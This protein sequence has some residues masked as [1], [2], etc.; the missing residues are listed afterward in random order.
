[1]KLPAVALAAFFCAGIALGLWCPGADR[2]SSPRSL[3]LVIA[4]AILGMSVSFALLRRGAL[5]VSASASLAVWTVLG[6]LGAAIAQQPSPPDFVL[7][8]VQEKHVDLRVALRWRVQLTNEPLRLPWGWRYDLALQSVEFQGETLRV[9]GGL[10]LN[11]G[12]QPEAPSPP[13]LH[14]GDTFSLLAQARLPQTYRNP[15]AFD[16][17]AYLA[18]QGVDLVATLRAPELIDSVQH[19][20]L[21]PSGHLIRLRSKLRDE[22]DDLCAGLPDQAAVLRAML[23]GDRSFIDRSESTDFQKTG[24]FHVLVVAGLHVAAFATFLF[25]AGRKLRFSVAGTSALIL[26]ALGVYVALVEQRPPVLRA[27]LMAAVVLVASCF[28]RRLDLLNSAAVAALILLVANPLE[29]RDSSFQ[30]SFL[31][32]ACIGGLGVPWLDRTVQPYA[33]ALH[34]WADVTRDAAHAPKFAQFRID[35][36]GVVSWASTF[37]PASMARTIPRILKLTFRFWELF[38]LTLVLQI[39]MLPV[40]ASDFHRV[41]LSGPVVNLIAVPLT[42]FVVP[43][44]FL[45]L[46]G[47]L[48]W[49]PL[50]ALAAMP[51]HWA[52]ALLL[53]AV[54]WFAHFSSF[55]YRIPAAPPWVI[56][57]FFAS[58]ILLAACLQYESARARRLAFAFAAALILTAVVVATHPFAPAWTSGRLE[59]N[60]LDVGQGDSLLLVSPKGHTLLIDG[61][62][63]FAGFLGESGRNSPD[64]GEEAVSPYLWSRGFKRIDVVALTHAHQDH[65]GGLV[66]VLENFGVGAL[67]VGPE[68]PAPVL[69]K[70]EAEA[71]ARGVPVI[72]KGRGEPFSWDGAQLQFLWPRESASA[73]R[74]GATNDDSLVLHVRYGTRSMLLPG[75]AEQQSEREMLDQD[76]PEDLRADVLKVG[77]HG[78]KNSTTPDFLSAVHPEIGIISVGEDNPYGHPSTDLLSR[79]AEA[80]VRILRTDRDGEVQVAMD[81]RN[82][83]VSCFVPCRDIFHA[84]SVRR[85]APK[86]QQHNQQQ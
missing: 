78:S 37:I 54:H 2:L 13:V 15:G 53:D 7:R 69:Q 24:V 79:L 84:S 52:T 8:A 26:L 45:A 4:G 36:R 3:W 59:L 74:S 55:S 40:L 76:P 66:A 41:T 22:V 9:S 83:N 49:H 50:G 14:V 30:L 71:R 56:L 81:G 80:H 42:G 67:W 44:G 27:A 47:G 5:V 19:A 70:L 68:V 35:L 11:Y 39:G 32:M 86:D 72:H 21:T 18:S 6:A 10:R 77:H 85:P 58:G 20:S 17:R 16:R 64:P 60:V 65:A 62:G 48:L 61:G 34:G 75:D 51:L 38:L 43:L 25:W 73:S 29:L 57:A 63:A 28:F 1:M 82:L 31:A 12:S 46:L 33:R 23:L